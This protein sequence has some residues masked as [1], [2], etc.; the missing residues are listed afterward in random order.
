MDQWI[1][2]H[3]TNSDSLTLVLGSHMTKEKTNISRL[4]TDFN[5]TPPI[6]K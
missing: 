5:I 1:K 6:N 3:M 4:S 2:E